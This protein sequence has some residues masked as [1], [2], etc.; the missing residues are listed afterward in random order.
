M[1][2]SFVREKKIICGKQYREADYFLTDERRRP[3]QKNKREKITCPSQKAL[4]DCRSR[5]YLIQLVNGNFRRGDLFVTCHYAGAPP[6]RATALRQARNYI[7]RI[8]YH[9]RKAGLPNARW[10][11]VAAITETN[12]NPTRIHHH[13]IVSGDFDRDKVE[14]LWPYGTCNTR[15][16]QSTG[17]DKSGVMGIA[18]YLTE[19][20][21]GN[22]KSWTSSTNLKRPERLPNADGKM[23]ASRLRK[24]GQAYADKAY[25]P[26]IERVPDI[27]YWRRLHPGW[28]IIS[29]SSTYADDFGWSI[30]L[31]MRRDE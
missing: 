10:I 18:V 24:L 3:G 16:I 30:C 28:Q 27:D 6:D 14:Q 29:Y 22:V 23:S 31:R 26:E 25:G 9:R 4:N 15:R 20:A 17:Y 2:K 11:M 21:G 1:R 19:Q 8:N 5:R 13:L 12:G 7:N